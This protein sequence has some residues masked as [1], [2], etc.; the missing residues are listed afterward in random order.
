MFRR[1]AA[2]I[3]AVLLLDL[4]AASVHHSAPAGNQ[5][6]V[7]IPVLPR[8]A[9]PDRHVAPAKRPAAPPHAAAPIA[10]GEPSGHASLVR[11]AT[12]TKTSW[13]ASAYPAQSRAGRSALRGGNS[14][15][16]IIGINDYAGSTRDNVGSYQDATSL[17]SYLTALGWRNDHIMLI[18]NRS[19]TRRHVIDGL[20]WLA[21]KTD[22]ASTVV[23]HYSGHEMP[24]HNDPDGDGESLD[25]ALWLADNNLLLDHDLGRLLS[26]IHAQ[27]MWLNFA[28]CRAGGFNDPGTAKSGRLITYSSPV[29]ELSYEDPSV[30]HSVFGYYSIVEGMKSGHADA[31][32]NGVATVQEAFSY[33]RP[34]VV[35]RTSSKQHPTMNDQYGSSF[36]LVPPAPPAPKQADPAPQPSSCTLPLGCRHVEP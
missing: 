32:G 5:A 19:A 23:F 33:A 30:S 25:V 9:D 36:S 18:G 20:R 26:P 10:I 28:V 16:L 24:F 31:N 17:R 21:S 8:R 29:G 7:S 11:S 14:W 3:A 4:V 12:A 6:A 35:D 27:K 34:R 1:T 2:L 13:V 15:A 22:A